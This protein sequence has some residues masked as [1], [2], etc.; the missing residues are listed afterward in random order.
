MMSKI[1][2]HALLGTLLTAGL[3][4]QSCAQ[5]QAPDSGSGPDSGV[6]APVTEEGQDVIL[7]RVDDTQ[8]TLAQF[9]DFYKDIPE[10]LQSGRMGT[11]QARDHV[12]T[13]IDMELLQ[14]E[15]LEQGI[16]QQP[17]FL[18]KN[19]RQRMDRLVGLYLIDRIKV[20]LTPSEVRDE[21]VEQGMSRTIR[22]AQILT[23][24]LDSAQAALNDIASGA[25]FG[26]A[27]RMWST[28]E[29]S[30]RQDGDSGRYSNRLDLPPSLGDRLFALTAGEI[31]EPVK[32]NR[33]FGIFTILAEFDAD[34]DEERFRA[35]YQQMYMDRSIAERRALVDSL[36]GDLQ[37]G[38]EK[39]SLQRLLEITTRG[40]WDEP[41]LDELTVYRYR[42]GRITGR[43]VVESV[44][45]VDLGSLRQM[46]AEGMVERMGRTLVPDAILMAA[47]LEAGYAERDDIVFWLKQR[48]R[49]EL[50]VQLRVKILAERIQITEEEIHAEYDAKPERYT[51]PERMILEEVLVATEAE[52]QS[53]RARIEAGESIATLAQQMSLRSIEHRDE[54][55][56]ISLTLADGR[57][58]GRLAASAYKT[59]PGE[60]VGPLPVNEGFSVYRM[61]DRTKEPATYEKSRRRAKATVNWIKKQIVFDE[62][63]KDLRIKYQDRVELFEDGI[64]RVATMPKGQ[65]AQLQ[66]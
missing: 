53:V 36:R 19:K 63:L 13:L 41:A 32:L 45:P 29:K 2:T 24:S 28:H 30:A 25:T 65:N 21:W 47:A 20:G 57:Y 9:R 58:L 49:E 62:F 50:I 17:A 16:D 40:A 43:D 52:A 61:L 15:A 11:D 60:L 18:S 31:S 12:Q 23:S 55:G 14:S 26:E 42:G 4:L 38:L 46:T 35:L 44:D 7:A 51:E 48:R 56:R 59:Q 1:R 54:N 10:Y 6:A 3:M 8:I 22:V 39:D 34:L 66:P 37:L 64:E 5:D 33:A 27:A